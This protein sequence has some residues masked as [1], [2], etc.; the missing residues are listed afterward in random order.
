MGK[1]SEKPVTCWGCECGVPLVNGYH[2]EER[3][4]RGLVDRYPCTAERPEVSR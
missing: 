4:V 3:G 1:D 2:E